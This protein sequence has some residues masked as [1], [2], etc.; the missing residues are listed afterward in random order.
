MW[1]GIGIAAGALGGALISSN[2]SGKASNAQSA[3]AGQS[4]AEQQREYNQT[5]ADNAP[6]LRTGTAANRRLGLLLGLPGMGPDENDQG[7]KA[8][9]QPMVDQFDQAH[10]DRFG[11][12]IWDNRADASSRDAQLERFKQQARDQYAAQYGDPSAGDPASGSLLRK[13]GI[14]DL[15][16]DPVYQSGLKF[17]ADQGRDAINARAT[18]G[19]M[20]DSG[21][22]LKA[23]TR[24]G[25]DYG[26]T[27][28]NES[29][30]RFT[31]DQNNIFNRLSGVSGTGQVATGQVSAA[32]A[33]MANNVGAAYEGAGNARAAGIVGGANAWGGAIN[34]AY[35]AYNNYQNNQ[36]LDALLKRYPGA[37][38][39][40]STPDYYYGGE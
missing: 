27:K 29:Y 23:L 38:G 12:S 7:Y 28:A 22:T 1:T 5:R 4:I 15:N 18:A 11:M 3:S 10:K 2:A 35:G 34:N 31:N 19:G 37:G 25:N 24:F 30:N 14:D 33:N 21:A 36:R 9:Y 13:F 6:F 16:A 17:G 40:T 20:Y 26:S 39:A 8:I 32:G